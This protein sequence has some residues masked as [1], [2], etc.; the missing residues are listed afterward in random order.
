[1]TRINRLSIG[2]VLGPF[3]GGVGMFTTLFFASDGLQADKDVVLAAVRQNGYSLQFAKEG[4]QADKE[5]VLAAVA[6][7]ETSFQFASKDLREGGLH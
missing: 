3:L 2:E 4:L 1:M 6:Q 7:D 5:V